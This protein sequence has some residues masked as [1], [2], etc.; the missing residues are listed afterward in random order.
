MRIIAG[1]FGGRR[2]LP[3]LTETTRPITDRA[4]QSLFDT[5]GDRIDGANV[6]DAFAGTGSMGLE[7]L[8]RGARRVVFVERDRGALLHLRKNIVALGIEERSVVLPIDAYRAIRHSALMNVGAELIDLAFIDPPYAHTEPGPEYAR[9]EPHARG[10]GRE[11]T[12]PRWPDQ[13]ATPHEGQYRTT[14]SPRFSHRA[15]TELWLDADQLADARAGRLAPSEESASGSHGQDRHPQLFHCW[16][17]PFMCGVDQPLQLRERSRFLRST[18]GLWYAEQGGL[19]TEA[20]TG[21]DHQHP[22]RARRRTGDPRAGPTLWAGSD[23]VRPANHP[24]PHPARPV[25]WQCRERRVARGRDHIRPEFPADFGRNLLIE[26]D[27]T[28]IST[29]ICS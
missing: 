25:S 20:D 28:A 4:K 24:G 22:S 15:G 26:K 27:F 17:N 23:P 13:P 14:H 3:P 2:I 7:C 10:A 5:L 19:L 29:A 11:S 12:S 6:L 16:S 9:L 21:H 1:E 18:L 8:S